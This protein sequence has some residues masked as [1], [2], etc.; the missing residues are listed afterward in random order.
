MVA[1]PAPELPPMP[2]GP[3]DDLNDLRFFAA[4]AEHGGFSAAARALG[5]PKSRLS[6]RIAS[7]EDRL[8]VRLLQRTTRR[9]VVTDVGERFLVHCRAMLEEAR[10]AQDAVDEL[11]SE[12]RGLVRVS[13]P[14]SIAQTALAPIVAQFLERHPA[15]TLRVNATNRRVDVLG[16][17]IDVAIRVR[18]RL[19]SDG[20]LVLR[21]IGGTRGLLVASPALLD[22]LGRPSLPQELARLPALSM[23]EHDNAQTWTLEHADGARVAVEVPAR[24]VCGDFPLLTEAAVAGLGV[25]M[26]PDWQCLDAL[27]SGALEVVLPQWQLPQGVLHFVYPSRRGLL[28]AVRAFV[29]HLAEGLAAY[30]RR[31]DEQQAQACTE[32]GHARMP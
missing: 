8:G 19:D 23:L 15:V 28:P 24:L 21:R 26:L 6:K 31:M 12:P 16:E 2:G 1:A 29:D 3:L 25:A 4:I 32:A 7:L 13:C 14:I 27:R 20:S 18:D 11:R 30:H 9:V 17:G 5:L 22:R 10:A